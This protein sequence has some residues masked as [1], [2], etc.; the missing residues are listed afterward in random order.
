[1]K[2]LFPLALVLACTGAA[3]A[4]TATPTGPPPPST[5]GST[6][7]QDPLGNTV[8]IASHLPTPPARDHRAQFDLIDGDRDGAVSRREAAVDKYLV[9]AF[10]ALDT[11][12]SGKLGYEEMLRWLDD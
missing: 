10:A 3:S 8:N 7:L 12:G 5:T 9:R 2:I 6:V 1:M 11:D 4:Q